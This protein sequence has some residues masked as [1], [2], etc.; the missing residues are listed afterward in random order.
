MQPKSRIMMK[1]LL[2]LFLIF[3][4]WMSRS[5]CP[6]PIEGVSYPGPTS[7]DVR[8]IPT[9]DSVAFGVYIA[10][11]GMPPPQQHE[12]PNEMS[13]NGSIY[14]SGLICDT[15]YNY[16]ISSFCA[17]GT[18][19]EWVGPFGFYTQSCF[20]FG[21]HQNL[22][23]CPV[24]GEACIDLH[25]NDSNIFNGDPDNDAFEIH[26]YGSLEDGANGTNEIHEA[27]ISSGSQT[28]F[29]FAQERYTNQITF[30]G[31]QVSVR[32][33]AGIVLNA[34]VDSNN[35]GIKDPGENDFP[36]GQFSYQIAGQ[37]EHIISTSTGFHKILDD[38][39]THIYNL[40][41]T[42][43]PEY[44][45][46][47]SVSAIAYANV[48]PP[49]TGFTTYYFPLVPLITYHNAA[50]SIAPHNAAM[51]GF[52]HNVW[53]T[54]TNTG[55]QPESGTVAFTNPPETVFVNATPSQG[56]S[57]IAT[58]TGF[59]YDFSNLQPFQSATI[60][61]KMQIPPIPTVSIGQILQHSAAVFIENALSENISANVAVQIRAAYDPN[62]KIEIHGPEIPIQTF[63]AED[64]LTYT[65]RFENTG[66]ANALNI[67]V[68]DVLDVKLDATTVKMVS[69]SHDVVMDRVGPNLTWRFNSVNLPP[70]SE[71][72]PLL[73]HGYLT[74]KV[75]PATGFTA[76]DVIPN[77]ASIYFDFN[78]AIVTE[79]FETKFVNLLHVA[80][81]ESE[82]FQMYPNPASD[83]ITISL[84][85][86]VIKKVKL[87]DVTGKKLKEENFES[88][89][90][91]MPLNDIS[92]GMYF[93]EITSDSGQKS[94]KKLIVK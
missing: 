57:I 43:N 75:K 45:P 23:A 54:Y 86:A 21:H 36:L 29:Y 11:A 46:Y 52:L 19:S 17:N 32:E 42:I 91:Q 50:V 1:Q 93:L 61:V 76:G 55:N 9:G 66:N 31:F 89:T 33:C 74:F 60:S 28:I 88:R 26:Y 39:Q 65:I 62:D 2:S 22:S 72:D 70:T 10:P 15:A 7:I 6:P 87:Y 12:Y 35:N 85:S 5:Q 3:S 71:T 80:S 4:V 44:A 37:S 83:Q 13:T 40:G 25:Q 63:T 59:T 90:V 58:P 81:N 56:G 49:S 78:P 41:Y 38:D 53:V 34:F 67:K 94:S 14:I 77:E 51:P 16:Y 24:N 30:N 79:T 20:E 68:T 8:C 92:S 84:S 82:N 47:Y 18:M 73:G 64:Y 27:C 48:N 69:A